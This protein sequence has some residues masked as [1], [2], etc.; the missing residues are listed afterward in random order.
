MKIP[1]TRWHINKKDDIPTTRGKA[2]YYGFGNYVTYKKVETPFLHQIKNTIAS[3]YALVEWQQ[4]HLDFDKKR[5]A[6]LNRLL[7]LEPNAHQNAYNFYYT[8]AYQLYTYGNVFVLPVYDNKS[9]KLK[10][11]KVYNGENHE[12]GFG[13]H[14]QGDVLYIKIKNK[15]TATVEYIPYDEIVH[16]RLNPNDI[17][18]GDLN[19]NLN[20]IAGMQNIFDENMSNFLNNLTENGT[21]KLVLEVGSTTGGLNTT[22]LGSDEK[23]DKANEVAA[24]VAQAEKD[25][26]FI[27]DATENLKELSKT[28]EY[29]SQEE[30]DKLLSVMYSMYGV[31]Q[32]VIN[33]TATQEEVEL[34]HQKTIYPLMMQTQ[35]EFNRKLLSKTA[36]TQGQRILGTINPLTMTP[37]SKLGDFIYKT[38]HVFEVN[39]LRAWKNIAPIKEGNKI[40]E[41]K[42]F[43]TN[44]DKIDEEVKEDE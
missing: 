9:F 42:N 8:I 36:Y 12:Y 19:E 11:M 40:L 16:L 31:N 3:S 38:G 25:G 30:M 41:N 15:E 35:Q 7:A 21:I 24:R 33:G 17:F 29:A 39:Q 27:T 5:D 32:K 43:L 1:L 44:V 34:F 37:L 4:I 18:Y 14:E 26:V 20:P 23:V 6:N 22:I 2:G 28:F 10:E 13:Y